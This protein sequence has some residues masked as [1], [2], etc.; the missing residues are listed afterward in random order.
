METDANGYPIPPKSL[1]ERGIQP[2]DQTKSSDIDDQDVVSIE[3]IMN[4]LQPKS[5]EK[6][7]SNSKWASLTREE[8][9]A[10]LEDTENKRREYQSNADKAAARAQALEEFYAQNQNA[11]SSQ[12]Q[13]KP[14]AAKAPVPEDFLKD[15]DPDDPVEVMA[16]NTKYL[17]AR[18]DYLITKQHEQIR[19]ELKREQAQEQVL[20]QAKRLA[21][22]D[23]RFRLP[24][25]EPN[26]KAIDGFLNEATADWEVLYDKLYGDG[27]TSKQKQVTPD[28]STVNQQFP[29]TL[30]GT[31]GK[32]P[33]NGKTPAGVKRLM[34]AF[35]GLDLPPGAFIKR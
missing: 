35:G 32:A 6:S 28:P 29:K 31:T 1:E 2:V 9:E 10:R 4:E 33:A 22:K 13:S 11:A 16:A 5:D 15:V 19:A 27:G 34:S 18:Q 24:N 20:S 30:S 3:E 7:Q 12:Q 14:A 26:L 23:P 21:N 8:L 25:G 17:E